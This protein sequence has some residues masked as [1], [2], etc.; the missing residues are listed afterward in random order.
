MTKEISLLHP[1]NTKSTKSLKRTKN[2]IKYIAKPKILE[3]NKNHFGSTKRSKHKTQS[4]SRR[5]QKKEEGNK[6]VTEILKYKLN[7]I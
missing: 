4:I 7:S 6:E 1:R 5:N 3:D 2:K